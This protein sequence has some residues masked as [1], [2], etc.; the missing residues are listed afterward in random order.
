M[1]ELTLLLPRSAFTPREV[2]RAGDVW[3]AFQDLAVFASIEVGWPPQRYRRE[4]C[5]F[6]VREM[7]VV[8]AR[9]TW[10]GE[11]L[12][13]RTCISR[14]RREMFFQR[15]CELEGDGASLIARATQQWVH[16]SADLVPARAPA[17]LTGAF[18]VHAALAPVDLP[19]FEPIEG[20]R[21]H[22]FELECWHTW[23]DPLGHVH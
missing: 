5:S 22:V 17:S 12:R 20:A 16:V 19:A 8:H 18:A 3:R 1:H 2:A 13:G 6:V 15:E 23:M 11:A 7:S 21:E 4:A 14:V 9:E 10:Y